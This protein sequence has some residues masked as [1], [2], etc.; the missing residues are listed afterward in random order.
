MLVNAC[1]LLF[2]GFS[3]LCENFRQIR[4]VVQ[5]IWR[6]EING[7]QWHSLFNVPQN[8][9]LRSPE[10]ERSHCCFDVSQG[11]E[12]MICA[13]SSEWLDEGKTFSFV[14]KWTTFFFL[15]E[16]FE[17]ERSLIRLMVSLTKDVVLKRRT[18]FLNRRKL[19]LLTMI[20]KEEERMMKKKK[21][22][23]KM[24]CTNYDDNW[25]TTN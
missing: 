13:A 9:V 12:Q 22:K 19:K 15:D 18:F 4:P 2:F 17:W 5:E 10:L 16:I 11:R 21:K 8:C 1:C 23:K 3:I 6:F 24:C 20:Q 25:G 14:G 7:S